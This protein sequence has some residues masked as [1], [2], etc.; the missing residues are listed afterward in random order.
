MICIGVDPGINGAI[1]AVHASRGLLAVASLPTCGSGA[2]PKAAIKQKV[3][4]A[5]LHRLLQSWSA[6]YDFARED[7]IAIVERMQPFGAGDRAPPTILLSMGHS[8]GIVEGVL[9]GRVRELLQ[10]L[11][12]QWK[13]TYGLGSNKAASIAEAKRLFPSVPKL[14]HDRAE[15]ILLAAWG[16][17]EIVTCHPADEAETLPF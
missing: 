4:A 7:V 3:D 5:G 10:V 9:M 12:Q 11:P 6:R 1:A 14:T 17:G 2:G 8:A 13:R 15:A 16:L